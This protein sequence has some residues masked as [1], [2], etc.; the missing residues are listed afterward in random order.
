MSGGKLPAVIDFRALFEAVPGLYL[1]LDA[2]L[3]I[4]AVN[5]AYLKATMTERAKIVGRSLFEVF[6][7]N[8]AEIGATGT[9]NLRASLDRVLQRR[10]ADNMAVQKYD[11]RLAE[12]EGGG[13]VE[14]YW[15]PVNT[16]MLDAQGQVE[17]IIHR[18]EDVTAYVRLQKENSARDQMTEALKVRSSEMES[19]IFARAQEIAKVNVDLRAEIEQRRVVQEQLVHE[20]RKLAEAN[21]ALISLQRSRDLLTG[22]II[23]DLRN[24]LTAS[25]GYLDLLLSKPHASE[26]HVR[27]HLT[28]ALNVNTAMMEMIN[29]IVDVMRME[30]GKMPVRPH[31]SDIATMIQDK[32]RHYR[33]AGATS[34]VSL[35]YDGPDRLA[36]QTDSVLLGRV[37][38]NLLVNALKHTPRGG[39]VTISAALQD[40]SG[41]LLVSVTDTGEGISPADQGR[42]FQKYGRVEGQTM[43]RAYDTGLG[44]VFCRMAIDLLHGDIAVTS[45][46]GKGS[47]FQIVLPGA[48]QA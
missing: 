46:L 40:G 22:M 3:M 30:D 41:H 31:P 18:V 19:E 20:S 16:P 8:P 45:A 21:A 7:D 6:P 15:S 12:S 2:R 26:S 27:T 43:G 13:F 36:F 23:H 29:G 5:D 25:I 35:H 42:L 10:V 17:F 32:L 34:E 44:L 48:G 4:V 9:T 38:D 47:R 11:I 37:I 1:I 39:A 33:G 14:R 24:P 28:N